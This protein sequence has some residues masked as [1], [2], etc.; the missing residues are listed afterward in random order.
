MLVSAVK[1]EL[2]GQIPPAIRVA[3]IGEAPDLA[4]AVVVADPIGAGYSLSQ[5]QIAQ[6]LGITQPDVS[7]LARAFKLKEDAECAVVVRK[8]KRSEM[9]NF[10]PRAIQRFRE[11][12]ADPPGHLNRSDAK[13]VDRARQ[14]GRA[15]V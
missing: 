11:L 1:P 4:I 12:I 14:I 9:V 5:D 10:H 6:A 13:A 8:G 2:Q 7:I 15:H 3:G